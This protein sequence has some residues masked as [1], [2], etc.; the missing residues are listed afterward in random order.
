MNIFS[1][2]VRTTFVHCL[3]SGRLLQ[4]CMAEDAKGVDA[5]SGTQPTLSHASGVFAITRFDPQTKALPGYS[6]RPSPRR[7]L[8]AFADGSIVENDGKEPQQHPIRATA[9]PYRP[10]V[11]VAS[12]GIRKALCGGNRQPG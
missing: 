11:T 12:G 9:T 2:F 8:R 1:P 7:H 6:V 3:T 10:D 5:K 4:S